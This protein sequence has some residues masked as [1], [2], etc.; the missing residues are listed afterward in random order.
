MQGQFMV[1]VILE[2][3]NRFGGKRGRRTVT[4]L[5][6]GS[7]VKQVLAD[8]KE[9]SLQSLNGLF[10]GRQTKAIRE[11]INSLI[12]QGLVISENI[13]VGPFATPVLRLT[14]EGKEFLRESWQKYSWEEVI[15]SFVTS[16]VELESN[17]IEQIL[18]GKKEQRHKAMQNLRKKDVDPEMV[19]MLL[20][21]W[22]NSRTDTDMLPHLIW[23]LG[24]LEHPRAVPMLLE[25]LLNENANTRRLACSALGKIKSPLA[26]PFLLE[27]LKDESP[28]VRYFAIKSLGNIGGFEVLETLTKLAAVEE[29]DYNIQ[30]CEESIYK[31]KKTDQV[32]PS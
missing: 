19:T 21:Y 22:R 32:I 17:L 23:A 24:E 1:I 13:M 9:F 29:L 3:I 11:T 16:K 5:L 27:T 2:V 7:K 20:D 25:F 15:G 30:A 31:L 10:L 18:I 14:Q 4:K 6:T 12:Y 28:R 26:V 8:V